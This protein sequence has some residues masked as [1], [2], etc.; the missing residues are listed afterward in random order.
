MALDDKSFTSH[1]VELVRY[2]GGENK[3]LV[4]NRVQIERWDGE[5]VD[6]SH[7]LPVIT[8]TLGIPGTPQVSSFWQVSNTPAANTIATVTQPAPGIGKRL[9]ISSLTVTLS[10][11][12]TSLLG[13]NGIVQVRNAASGLVVWSARLSI[14]AVAGS[15]ASISQAISLVSDLNDSLVLEFLAIP[16]ANNFETVAMNGYIVND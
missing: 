6:A 16:G 10:S 12:L 13:F 3:R 2:T 15:I 7:P 1:S 14:A 11:G 8:T 9:I 4:G 5:S